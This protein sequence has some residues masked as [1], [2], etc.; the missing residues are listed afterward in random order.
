M[1]AVAAELL[2]TAASVDADVQLRSL[3]LQQQ[4]EELERVCRFIRD[5]EFC[6]VEQIAARQAETSAL[7]QSIQDAIERARKVRAELA[8]GDG[9]GSDDEQDQLQPSVAEDRE[10]GSIL[11]LA[12]A[13][14]TAQQTQET[15]EAEVKTEVKKEQEPKVRLEYPRKLKAMETQL[16]E[17]RLKE[18]EASTRFAFCCKMSEHLSLSPSRRQL[19]AQQQEKFGSDGRMDVPVTRIQ[20]SFPKQVA[21]LRGGYQRLT[22]FLLEKIEV[23]SPAFRQVAEAPT[24]SKVFPVYHRL[25]QVRGIRFAAVEVLQ[26]CMLEGDY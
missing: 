2:R 7:E 16:E 24:F 12:K 3:V 21:R 14:R 4:C 1:D 25:K 9:D 19:I 20:T 23:E 5:L 11:A 15:T 26:Y 6:A 13:T 22:A 8:A 18:R 17:V 10:L